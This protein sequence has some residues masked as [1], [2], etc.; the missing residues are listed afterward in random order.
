MD[1]D[2]VLEARISR[3]EVAGALAAR[4]FD[5][6]VA[7]ASFRPAIPSTGDEQRRCIKIVVDCSGSMGGDSA[8]QARVALERILDGL[9][10]GDLFEIIAFGSNWHALF[11]RETVVTETTLAR[12][13]RFVRTLDADMGGTEIGA[14]LDAAYAVRGASGALRDLLLI[15]DGEVWDSAAVIARARESGHRIFTVGV[16]SAVAE[17]LVQGLAEATGGACE[18]VTPREDMAD[19]IHRHFQRM[20]APRI[21]SAGVRWPA[22][23]ESRLPQSIETVYGGDT[24]H[25]FAWFAEKP[26][27]TASLEVEAGGR[28]RREPGYSDPCPRGG[29]G[30][31]TPLQGGVADH[32]G[33]RCRR[34]EDRRN[35]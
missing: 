11:D 18:L 5:G 29:L 15:T 16:G 2:F 23:P 30:G 26:E 8:A 21:R 32:L 6:W 17:A 7:L 4:D 31:V 20:Y 13:R 22:P 24:V 14:A 28:T 35:G 9:R 34:S 25:A 33:S 27:G 3:P 10:E 12:A 19:R 1:R